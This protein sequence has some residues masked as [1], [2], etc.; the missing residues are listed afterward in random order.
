MYEKIENKGTEIISEVQKVG[1]DNV[2]E[3]EKTRK[4]INATIE[5][6]KK[7][8]EEIRRASEEANKSRFDK[9]MEKFMQGSKI[10]MTKEEKICLR[11]ILPLK[12]LQIK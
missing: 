11:S 9:M 6:T 4:E 1:K 7:T 2:V 8:N 10:S 5:V 3:H 12:D